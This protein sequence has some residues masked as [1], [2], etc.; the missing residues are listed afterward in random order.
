MHKQTGRDKMDY[1]VRK[2][3][4]KKQSNEDRGPL[5]QHQEH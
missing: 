4:E 3:R 2:E 1:P 5:G